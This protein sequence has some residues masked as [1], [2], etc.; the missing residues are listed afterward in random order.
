MNTGEIAIV[1]DGSEE[2]MMVPEQVL[3]LASPVFKQM[4][5]HDMMEKKNR[6]IQLPAKDR[7]EIK[8]LLA[9]LMPATSRLQTITVENVDFLLRLS[10]EYCID[11][12]KQECIEFVKKQPPSVERVL[13]A[14]TYGIDDYLKT[15]TI[16]L[17]K[18]DVRNWDICMDNPELMCIIFRHALDVP[19]QVKSETEESI[20][21]KYTGIVYKNGRIGN[22]NRLECGRCNKPSSNGGLYSYSGWQ[23]KGC[24]SYK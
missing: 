20:K 18:G 2:S 4:L 24:A 21:K 8:I 12:I 11:P 22:G 14:Y 3:T 13:Q 6:T 17:I 5:D 9:F 10:N 23:C 7:D 16:D 15:C 19:A 1:F